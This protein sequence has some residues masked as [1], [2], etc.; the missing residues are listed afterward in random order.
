MVGEEFSGRSRQELQGR[1]ISRPAAEFWVFGHLRCLLTS[2]EP[3]SFYAY[4]RKPCVEKVQS[5]MLETGHWDPLG[6]QHSSSRL[7]LRLSGS[8]F[9]LP[10][11]TLCT[12]T[13]G[14]WWELSLGHSPSLG[15]HL[16]G[17][18]T[19]LQWVQQA[20][21]SAELPSTSLPPVKPWGAEPHLPL[22]LIVLIHYRKACASWLLSKHSLNESPE[23][24]L[25]ACTGA[26]EWE[27]AKG[28][29]MVA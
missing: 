7:W 20:D 4:S 12:P 21:S 5:H 25:N 3:P 29:I 18:R 2:S 15:H 14:P 10:L 19:S 6:V 1:Q 13:A 11:K 16:P 17:L 28:G 26:W 9:D 8:L 24:S 23:G 27:R 22:S